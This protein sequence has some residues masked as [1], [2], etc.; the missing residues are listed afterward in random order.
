MFQI[1]RPKLVFCDVEN[2]QVVK[3][4]LSAA[5]NESQIYTFGGSTDQSSA[6]DELFCETGLESQFM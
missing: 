6:I 4:S 5:R 1:T 3:Q 2:V